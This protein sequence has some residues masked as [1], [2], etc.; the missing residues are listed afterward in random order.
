MQQILF[1]RN[2]TDLYPTFGGPLQRIELQHPLENGGTAC[3]FTYDWGQSSNVLGQGTDSNRRITKGTE[4]TQVRERAEWMEQNGMV[5]P[6]FDAIGQP[7]RELPAP[8]PAP[9]TR[10]RAKA[11]AK[12]A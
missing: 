9:K 8:T 6:L 1:V 4:T 5:F 7:A 11:K 12:A 3:R 2:G 10:A